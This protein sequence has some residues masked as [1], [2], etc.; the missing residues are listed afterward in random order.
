[1]ADK[2]IVDGLVF[3]MKQRILGFG[4]LGAVLEGMLLEAGL[5]DEAD[6]ARGRFGARTVDEARDLGANLFRGERTAGPSPADDLD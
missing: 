1:M 5:I 4:E 3:V 2:K 6:S